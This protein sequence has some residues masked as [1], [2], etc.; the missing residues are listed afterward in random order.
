MPPKSDIGSRRM[1]DHDHLALTRV[2]RP[3]SKRR[4]VGSAYRPPRHYGNFGG[5]ASALDSAAADSV[6]SFEERRDQIA[7]IDPKLI[8]RFNI[9]RRVSEDEWRRSGLTVLDSGDQDAVIVF[10]NEENLDLFRERLTAYAEGPGEPQPRADG[11]GMTDPTARYEGFFDAI[12]G[13]RFTQ[14]E[15]RLSARL[16]VALSGAPEEEHLIDVEYWFHSDE[17]TLAGWMEEAESRALALGGELVD[18]YVSA[19][20]NIALARFRGAAD[21]IAA[22]AELDQVAAID[23]VP[24]PVLE[25]SEFF[26]LQDVEGL[27]VKSPE[28]DAPVVGL[29]DSGILSGHPILDPAVV[30]AVAIH[31]EFGGVGEDTNGHGSMVAGIYLYGDVLA[32]ARAGHFEADFWLASVRVLDDDA[33]VPESVNWVKAIS[34]AVVYL[35]ES[36]QTRVINISI[37]DCEAPFGGGKST[38]LAAE[39]DTLARRY[40]LIFVISAGN[41]EEAEIEHERWPAYLLEGTGALLD[42]GQASAAITVGAISASDG[43]TPGDVGSTLEATAVAQSSGPAPFTRTG[44]GVRGAI[45]PEVSANGGNCR[46]DHNSGELR[47]DAAIEVVSASARF[48]ERLYDTAAGTSFAAPA[49]AN[50]AG[51]L[52]TRYPGYSANAIRALMLQGAAHLPATEA[53]FEGIENAETALHSLCGYGGLDWERCGFSDDNRVVMVAEDELLPEDFHVFRIPMTESFT[54]VSG[55][56]LVTVGLAFTPPVR[57]RR[58]DYLAFQ[59]DF[60]L[61]RGIELD[62]VFELVSDDFDSGDGESLTKHERAMRPTRTARSKGA[63]QMARHQSATRPIEKFHDDW[64]LVVKSFNKWMPK[65]ADPQPYGLSVCLESERSTELYVELQAELRAELEAQA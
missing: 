24:A 26:D 19:S 60:Q 54:D 5:H 29:I 20:S 61:V 15:D 49:V 48:P 21:L 9:N 28:G 11:D 50:V 37:G 25:R 36:W 57:H 53:H 51:R 22:L 3:P 38:P 4:K 32:A 7:D 42:P 43:L 58:F 40:R 64:Y 27:E 35:A 63:N 41:L 62:E 46:L 13:L 65:D 33:R 30:E 2:Q 12:D 47:T 14:P 45:K 34:E 17:D 56:H 55:N 18:E 44:P 52:L 31:P 10:A 16:E 6:S 8:L 59:M 39:L 23:L 1:A